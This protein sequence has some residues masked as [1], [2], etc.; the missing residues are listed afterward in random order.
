MMEAQVALE[1][2]PA[3]EG[4]AA[5]ATQEDHQKVRTAEALTSRNPRLITRYYLRW[6]TYR[7]FA[8]FIN[9]AMA[10]I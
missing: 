9:K 4:Q 6:W 8:R 5:R 1:M 2:T 10:K 3:R 7:M